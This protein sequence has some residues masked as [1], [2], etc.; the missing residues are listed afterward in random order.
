[1]AH[2]DD[3]HSFWR[4]DTPL[5]Q[6]RRYGTEDGVGGHE[7]EGRYGTWRWGPIETTRSTTANSKPASTMRC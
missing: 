1:M 6:S 4:G 3:R 5:R 2:H 7:G